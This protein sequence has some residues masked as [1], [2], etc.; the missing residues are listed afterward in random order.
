MGNVTDFEVP[1]E[2]EDEEVAMEGVVEEDKSEPE[3]EKEEGEEEE[4]DKKKTDVGES[5]PASLGSLRTL[6]AY[7]VRGQLN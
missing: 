1:V 5:R 3:D 7:C 2:D 4:E 6:A